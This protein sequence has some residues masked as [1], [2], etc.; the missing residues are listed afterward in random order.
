MQKIKVK[1]VGGLIP[2]YQSECAAGCD[3]CA[4]IQEPI[5]L[6][7]DDHLL[8]PTGIKIEIPPGFEAQVRPR[9]GLA[10]KHGIGV[11]NGPGTIDADY[12]GEVKVILF[13]FSKVPFKISHGDR[14]AQ[15]VFSEVVQ[16]D[17][18]PAESLSPSTRGQGG[19]GH[20]GTE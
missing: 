20:T 16:A 2:E 7:P 9:S 13:N 1:V 19:F 3:L 12:R 4:N 10:A 8:V 17:F 14:I 11:L 15:L 6:Q 5:I 18:D